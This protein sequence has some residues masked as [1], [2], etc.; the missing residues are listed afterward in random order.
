ML[1]EKI[2]RFL[3]GKSGFSNLGEEI[4][5]KKFLNQLDHKKIAVDIAANDGI[6]MSNTYQLY[7]D[8]YGGLAVECDNTAFASLSN[9]YKKFDKVFLSKA[10]IYPENVVSLLEGYEIP[11]DF[12]FLSFDIDGYDYFVMK[13][14]LK[15]FRPSLICVEINE[16]I[17]YPIK[18]TIKY[19][20]DYVWGV[21]HFFGQSIGQVELLC[22]EYNY[23][24]VEVYYNNAF[25]IPTEKNKN[26][27]KLEPGQAYLDGYV[28][29][30]D[31]TSKFPYNKDVDALLNM[32]SEEAL[33]FI[34]KYFESY[35]GKYEL[36]L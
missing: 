6:F 24:L 22:K 30:P 15:K 25:L 32:K 8:G 33:I 34:K 26:F 18:F 5:I 4:I 11:A 12:G 20:R 7:K 35:E 29:K 19:N 27:N 21:N 9:S 13:E 16:K 2:K 17:P 1:K 3:K 36:S 14:L 23:D 10:Y 28:N 31:R